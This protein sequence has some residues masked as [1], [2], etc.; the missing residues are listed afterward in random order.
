MARQNEFHPIETAGVGDLVS[1][2]WKEGE[3]TR[4]ARARI[5]HVRAYGRER[6]LVS[7][8]GTEFARYS[9]DKLKQVWCVIHERY[10]PEQPD[11]FQT[12]RHKLEERMAS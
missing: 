8:C 4:T 2:T 10:A 9:L 12:Q 3:V 5:A 7:T 11:L 6:V 1:V